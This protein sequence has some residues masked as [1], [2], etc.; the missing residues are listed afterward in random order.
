VAIIVGLGLIGGCATPTAP[1]GTTAVAPTAPVPASRPIDITDQDNRGTVHLRTGQVIQFSLHSTYWSEPASVPTS[2]L[3]I[4]G[5][6]SRVTG[7]RCPIG[8]GCGTVSA[9]FR[10]VGAGVARLRAQ[11]STCGEAMLCAPDQRQFVVT[12]VVN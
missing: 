3:A 5:A 8:N 11:R 1:S 9:R 4:D 7:G 2:V 12:V 6:V 10:A